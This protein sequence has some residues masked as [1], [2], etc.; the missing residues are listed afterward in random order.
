M[1]FIDEV[2]IEVSAGDGGRGCVA[3]RREALVPRGGPS[4]GDGGNGGDVVFVADPQLGT[5][6]DLRYRRHYR[7]DRGG[8]GLGSDCYGRSAEPLI[9]PVPCGTVVYAV[10][11][12]ALLADLCQPGMRWV[13][14]RGGRGG[15][16]N[17]HFASATNRAPRRADPGT[18]GE[19]R[20]LRLEL[21]LVAEVGLVGLPNAGKSTLLAALSAA[22]PKIA[23]YPFTTLTPGLG[24]VRLNEDRSCVM[25]D[26]PGLIAG[27]SA[28]AGLGHRF[29]RHIER[30]RV[31]IYLLDDRHALLGEEGGPA[32]DLRLLRRELAAHDP[33]LVERPTLVVLNK[34]DL[35]D[36][37]REA[38]IRADLAEAGVTDPCVISAATRRGLDRLLADLDRCLGRL[39]L[40][41]PPP[42]VATAP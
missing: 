9:V 3:F 14:A 39:A 20:Q 28:G 1:R 30:T 2:K 41:A 12:G 34:A 35:F 24:L 27:A 37:E 32:D 16:G 38:A 7:A 4:G 29:L 33:A 31:L 6:L 42:V 19:T 11:G 8:H 18:P 40:A 25:A 36:S 21:K 10:E 13:A 23:D 17:I 26:I 5:L 15:R 22:R